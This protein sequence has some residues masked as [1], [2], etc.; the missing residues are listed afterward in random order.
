[1]KKQNTRLACFLSPA[2]ALAA[3][4]ALQPGDAGAVISL[5]DRCEEGGDALGWTIAANGD[6]N[7]DG[8]NDIAI[9]APCSSRGSGVRTKRNTGNV[10][11]LSGVDGTRLL[12]RKGTQA[13]QY[14][15]VGLTFLPD[16]NNDGKDELAIGSP[17]FDIKPKL[18]GDPL[19]T[20]IGA[21][22]VDVV[23]SSGRRRYRLLGTQSEGG[24]GELLDVSAD[25]DDDG[26]S[27][28]I[29]SASNERADRNIRPGRVHVF[30]GRH[31]D[32]IGA[33]NGTKGGEEFGQ[34]VAA[35]PDV[36]GD[37]KPDLVIGSPQRNQARVRYSGLVVVL[38]ADL[39]TTLPSLEA[40]GAKR[41][42]L[43][44]A[45]APAGD[46]NGDGV[47]EFA[48]SAFTADDQGFRESGNIRVLNGFGDEVFVSG[49]PN[50]QEFAHFG[51]ALANVGDVTDDGID[52]FAVG[53][54]DRDFDGVSDVGRM[55]LLDG[56]LGTEVWSTEGANPLARVGSS[57]AK[58]ADFDED[59][60]NDVA[61][62]AIGGTFRG[63][64]GAGVVTFLSAETGEV[65]GEVG[66]RRGLE[67][68]IYISGGNRLLGYA[69]SGEF[70]TPDTDTTISEAGPPSMAVID[71]RG[72]P[73]PGEVLVA[74]ALGHGG[75]SGEVVVYDAGRRDRIIET[76]DALADAE[77]IDP[78]G[79][80][81][82]GGVYVAAGLLGVGSQQDR[83]IA[84]QADSRDGNVLA[85]VFRRLEE[86]QSW[87]LEREFAAFSSGDEFPISDTLDEPIAAEGATVAVGN[88]DLLSA[89]HEIV[90]GTVSDLPIV[91]VLTRLGE[92]IAEWLAYSPSESG[93]VNVCIAKNMTGGT[94]DQ[95]I[96]VPM[97]GQPLIK[98]FG[99]QGGRITVPETGEPISIVPEVPGDSQGGGR[100]CAADVDYDGQPEIVYVA[101]SPSEILVQAYE[102]DGSK[103][104][105]FEPFRTFGSGMIAVDNFVSR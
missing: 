54:P 37:F 7:G 62:G 98:V 18:S 97:E 15:G 105:G 73:N 16:T 47:S 26:R 5:V 50:P 40:V 78:E 49:D 55:V 94:R 56:V 4:I 12:K 93:G 66:G 86:Q 32:A 38:P 51:A 35:L 79:A 14:M 75:D 57:V 72:V 61:V 74:V 44:W 30:S 10:L 82:R 95:I 46:R 19:L 3:L 27:E 60:E 42:R 101:D 88:V 6:F 80:S 48:V 85:R 21:G 23:N 11:V 92:P 13:D 2:F 52:D 63:R 8:V 102:I 64:R 53:A 36:D 39:S 71:D 29:V 45:I 76:F 68:R 41:D 91:R 89:G 20:K 104:E 100:A 9:G 1:M 83:L 31:G 67:T 96:T 84:V 87:F 25:Q 70:E 59:G 77:P 103:V 81:I 17:G 65:I 90:L 58:T 33:Y 28:L 24:F 69:P 34:G 22:K 43:G 99:P